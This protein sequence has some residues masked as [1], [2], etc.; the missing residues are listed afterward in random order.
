MHTPSLSIPP[1]RSSYSKRECCTEHIHRHAVR[2][3]GS[4][5]ITNFA[6][7]HML[8][9]GAG[10]V[11]QCQADYLAYKAASSGGAYTAMQASC[12]AAF[13]NPA[14]AAL[15]AG[16]G[17]YATSPAGSQG[18]QAASTEASLVSLPSQQAGR[19]CCA[20]WLRGFGK[21]SS[22]LSGSQGPGDPALLTQRPGQA[23][24]GS[25]MISTV[26]RAKAWPWA[27]RALNPN[28]CLAR[29]AAAGHGGGHGR[30]RG[31]AARPGHLRERAG[32]HGV[33]LGRPAGQQ[34]VRAGHRHAGH[35]RPQRPG[36]AGMAQ[37]LTLDPNFAWYCESTASS[38]Y[39]HPVR[40]CT[41]V[42]SSALCNLHGQRMAGQMA[43][44]HGFTAPQ[45]CW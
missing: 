40:E 10:P 3:P 17:S 36:H 27:G 21:C 14:L 7:L 33:R 35:H 1:T 45:P 4:R 28:P 24:G 29:A 26:M 38:L 37:D 32:P 34:V 12:Q 8:L 43:C 6:N 41:P 31:G 30:E 20:V 5:V 9:V 11:T 18:V 22:G 2:L 19:P 25:L 13:G 15:S 23:L 44:I 16:A 39:A 42:R